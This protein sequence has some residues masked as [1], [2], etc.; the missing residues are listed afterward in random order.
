MGIFILIIILILLLICGLIIKCYNTLVQKRNRVE[1]AWAQIDVQ[2][3]KRFDLIPNLMETVKGM[4][5]YEKETFTNIVEAR[6]RYST[7]STVDDK[8]KVSNESEKL[9]NSINVL[10]EDYPELKSNEGYL[11]FMD[12]LNNIEEQISVSRLFYNDT[13]NKFNDEVMCFPNNVIA[14][15]FGFKKHDLFEVENNVRE[16]I[17]VSF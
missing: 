17:K 9:F 4:C 6:N 14:S 13:V 5:N 2:L 16:N 7:A 3:Q 1:N 12:S 8:I 15:I 10:H 11:K